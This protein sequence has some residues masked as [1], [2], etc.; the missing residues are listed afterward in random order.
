MYRVALAQAVQI[1]VNE[2][3][4]DGTYLPLLEQTAG[5]VTRLASL[6]RQITAWFWIEG[7]AHVFWLALALLAIDLVLDWTFRM[8]RAQRAVL[9]ALM[10][11]AL[12]WAVSR[13][14][15][16]PLSISLGDDVLALAVERANPQLGQGLITALQLA[17]LG[18]AQANGLS[19][20]LV[21]RAVLHGVQ[22]AQEVSFGKV[23]NQDRHGRNV[24]QL[25]TAGFLLFCLAAGTLIASPLQIWLSRNL[26]LSSA[27][28]PQQTYL[29]IERLA[30]DGTVVFP[31]GDD[32]TQGV[33]VRPDSRQVPEV[34]YFDFR[35]AGA[36]SGLPLKRTGK[37]QFETRFSNVIEP[38]EFRARGGDAVT[39][40][41]R[42][43]LVEP[44]EI[45]ELRLIVTPPRYVG[46]Q[47]EELPAGRG[48]YQI[49]P[50]SSLRYEAKANT[51][52][53]S[54]S[55]LFSGEF[56]VPRKRPGADR[57]EDSHIT[58]GLGGG[59]REFQQDITPDDLLAGQY[60]FELQDT[61]G[62]TNRQPITFSLRKRL[63]REPRVRVRLIG[64]GGLV[65]PQARIPFR[66]SASD[67][68]GL[69]A[70]A[71]RIRW[72]GN[73][74]TRPAGE[75]QRTFA[76]A[77]KSLAS[78]QVG[79]PS[80]LLE[81]SFEDAIDLALLKIPSGTGL[82]F[83]FEASDN[84][85]ISGPNVGRSSE[86]LVRIVTEEELRTDLLRREKELRQELER[87][88]KNQDELVTSSRA[89][90][91]AL[92]GQPSLSTEQQEQL[93]QDHKGQ[94]RNGQSTASIAERLAAIVLEVQ[95]NRLEAPGGRLQTRL[96][97]EIIAPLRAVV[98]GQ[99][100]AAVTALDQTRWA[101]TAQA[102]DLALA[103]AIAHQ[104]E[105]AAK[106]KQ[107]L[108]HLVQAEGFQE[109]VNLLY[110]IQQAQT[111]VNDQTNQARQER[112]K[113]I[114]EGA[115]TR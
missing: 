79:Q 49:L 2:F 57:P 50:G 20:A 115:G 111:E 52:L 53:A 68:F 59:Q 105:A 81:L 83:R 36:R 31:R 33:S 26:L 25:L 29:V 101:S 95:N 41:V 80:E 10:L 51:E 22:V 114:L 76:E 60:R 55:L 19:P 71:A 87:L 37:R 110:E 34:V 107:I 17:R 23:I 56:L 58:I 102:R 84:D 94:K 88:L 24:I 5:V 16:R 91:A 75:D 97:L 112:I 113:R 48:P 104:M 73:D 3:M 35:R 77:D 8:D 40:W 72:Q 39:D 32:W 42:V 15:A 98:E 27:T 74:A 4:S 100:A 109:A 18:D 12:G 70:V 1:A 63:D 62:L 38:F 28:W 11:S 45:T 108:E 90:A 9:L 43:V 7:L 13:W 85:D 14:L 106:M 69:T 66:C 54:A 64:V 21:R 46:G 67:D 82:S 96:S 78:T 93:G 47:P 6:R 65:T 99:I 92:P 86:F 89:L 44:P 61:L 30:A 103:A